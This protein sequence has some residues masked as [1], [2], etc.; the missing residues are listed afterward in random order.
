MKWLCKLLICVSTHSWASDLCVKNELTYFSCHAGKEVISVCASTNPNS[1]Q[2]RSGNIH[3]INFAYPENN[4]DSKEKLFYSEGYASGY[5]EKHLR[6]NS[7]N[8]I[9]VIFDRWY[10][11]HPTGKITITRGVSV[12]KKE[13]M[14]LDNETAEFKR[15][16]LIKEK[17]CNKSTGIEIKGSWANIESE[18]F[19]YGP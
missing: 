16:Y 4:S 11:D 12:F 6:F 8:K 14:P 19:I 15:Q 10:N 9:Y 18:N 3:K 7:K 13:A 17:F 5:T 2:F 1:T